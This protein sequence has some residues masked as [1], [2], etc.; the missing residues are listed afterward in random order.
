MYK[1]QAIRGGNEG[2][3]STQAGYFAVFTRPASGGLSEKLRIT[4]GGT[5]NITRK[6]QATP[7]AGNGT[8]TDI[9]LDTDGGDIATGRIFLQGYQKSANSDFMT[10]IN[11]EGTSFVLYVYSM[12]SHA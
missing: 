10:G 6:N 8:F 1:R 7:P 3:A 4:S 12:Q 5:V 2:S 9:G 11:N